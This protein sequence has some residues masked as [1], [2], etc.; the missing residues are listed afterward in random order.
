MDTWHLRELS[1]SSCALGVRAQPGAK[2]S[3]LTGVWNGRLK[4]AVRAPAQDGRANEEVIEVLAA[5]FGIKRK[6]LALSGGEKNRLKEIT[7]AL[8][9]AEARRRLSEHL[10]A[11]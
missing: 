1:A 11:G 2:H 10:A 8:P 5:A 3:G 9:V 4:V 7:L 6:E